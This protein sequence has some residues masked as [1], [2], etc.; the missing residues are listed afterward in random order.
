MFIDLGYSKARRPLRPLPQSSVVNCVEAGSDLLNGVAGDWSAGGQWVRR[1]GR[2]IILATSQNE[3]TQAPAHILSACYGDLGT[4]PRR[5][6][7]AATG[8]HIQRAV[9]WRKGADMQG[10][11]TIVSLHQVFCH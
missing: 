7:S 2:E 3:E 5:H 8:R 9:S 11:E 6:S 10:R 1:V 4:R